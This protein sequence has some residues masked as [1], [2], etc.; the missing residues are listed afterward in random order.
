MIFYS[1]YNEHGS[2][3]E[4]L[5]QGHAWFLQK[6]FTLVDLRQAIQQVTAQA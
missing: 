1:G 2:L 6:P 4:A 5:D 3:G